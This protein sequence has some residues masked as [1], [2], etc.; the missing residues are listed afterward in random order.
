MQKMRHYIII[1]I[2][3]LFGCRNYTESTFSCN[4]E[5]ALISD[6]DFYQ[7][8]IDPGEAI[9]PVGYPFA[10]DTLFSLRQ[11]DTLRIKICNI[12]SHD[13][14]GYISLKYNYR[15]DTI[16]IPS[17]MYLCNCHVAFSQRNSFTICLKNDSC[18][19]RKEIVKLEEISYQKYS[20]SLQNMFS[21]IFENQFKLWNER[22]A[23]FNNI[24]SLRR[25][26]RNELY[27]P[28]LII[29][30]DDDSQ[31]QNLR[32]YIDNAYDIYLEE[33]NKSIVDNYY[34]ELCSLSHLEFKLFAYGLF[35]RI[36]IFPKYEPPIVIPET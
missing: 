16:Y 27:I 9:I 29:E 7:N 33:L 22:K 26:K 34:K 8:A 28:S 14:S 4:H 31:I 36:N 10:F 20:D 23:Y 6:K 19:I 32:K 21:E 17:F 12:Q 3:L 24:D 30:L 15:H 5:K 1:L 2:S 35:F 25:Y 11:I 13:C 18:F